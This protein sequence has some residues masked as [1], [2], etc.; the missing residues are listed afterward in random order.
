[1]NQNNFNFKSFDLKIDEI[2]FNINTQ[3]FEKIQM[4][5]NY[6]FHFDEGLLFHL[7]LMV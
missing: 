2:A 5:A 4:I 7:Q 6:M 1:M 3:D